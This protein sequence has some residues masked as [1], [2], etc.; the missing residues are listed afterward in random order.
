[1][2]HRIGSLAATLLVGVLF[3]SACT[4]RQEGGG[5]SPELQAKA[6]EL[7]EVAKRAAVEHDEQ[8]LKA[9]AAARAP[10]EQPPAVGGDEG[11]SGVTVRGGLS[12]AVV[13]RILRSRVGQVGRCY[14]R[15]LRGRAARAGVVVVQAAVAPTGQVMTAHVQRSTLGAPEVERCVAAVVRGSVFPRPA[16]GGMTIVSYPFRFQAGAR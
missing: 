15:S 7:E 6:R 1:M 14:E 16:G 4:Q 12:A 11:A 8:Q 9:A 3:A 13:H 10:A 2:P 5:S